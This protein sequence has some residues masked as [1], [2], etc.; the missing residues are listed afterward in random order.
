[1]SDKIMIG[2]LALVVG[3]FSAY[4]QNEKQPF[5]KLPREEQQSLT[6]RLSEYVKA[7]RNRNWKAL[8]DLVSDTGKSGVNRQTFIAAMT[9]KHA[10]TEYADMPDLLGFTPDRSEEDEDG[11]DIYGC[12]NA[13]REGEIYTGIAVIHAVHEHDTWSFTGWSFTELPNEPCKRLSDPAWKPEG[14]M[15]WKK[16]MDEIKNI[17]ASRP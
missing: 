12:S 1:M 17:T 10:G 5:S 11:I 3:F 6:H 7:Y 15:E 2:T 9:A 8:Y 14:R 13:K 4:A 16:P